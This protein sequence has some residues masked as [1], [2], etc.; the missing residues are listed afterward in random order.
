MFIYKYIEILYSI[1]KNH[2]KKGLKSLLI[3]INQVNNIKSPFDNLMIEIKWKEL[4]FP[5]GIINLLRN[6]IRILV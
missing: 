2:H 6:K 4:N 3:D 1:S 5:I